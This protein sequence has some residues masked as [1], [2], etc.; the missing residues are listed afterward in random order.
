MI[1]LNPIYIDQFYSVF[2]LSSS[3]QNAMLQVEKLNSRGQTIS[4]G[5]IPVA[6]E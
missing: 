2:I 5:Y 6:I 1:L 3:E 4:T